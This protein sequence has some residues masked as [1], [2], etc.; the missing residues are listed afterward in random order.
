MDFVKRSYDSLVYIR[1]RELE[2]VLL[3]DCRPKRWLDSLLSRSGRFSWD[4][5][6][7]QDFSQCFTSS[8]CFT[9]PDIVWNLKDGNPFEEEKDPYNIQQVD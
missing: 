2:P 5:T 9:N 3:Y 6:S 4:L 7:S 1:V 8:Q